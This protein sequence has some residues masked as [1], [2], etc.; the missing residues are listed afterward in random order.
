[1]RACELIVLMMTA[2]VNHWRAGHLASTAREIQYNGL[3]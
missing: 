2:G 3:S 1:M